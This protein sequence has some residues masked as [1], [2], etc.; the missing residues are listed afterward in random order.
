MVFLARTPLREHEV[1][2]APRRGRHPARGAAHLGYRAAL[3]N[4]F[5]V[6]WAIFGVRSSLIP[7]FVVEGLGSVATWT[8]VGFFVSA[9]V[10]GSC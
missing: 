7:L 5:A 2:A 8:G 6:G 9:A 1:A 4:N 10:Q 3:A